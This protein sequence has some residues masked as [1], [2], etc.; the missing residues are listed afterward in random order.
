MIRLRVSDPLRMDAGVLA[1]GSK[2]PGV[3]LVRSE[4]L[5]NF[6]SSDVWVL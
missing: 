5:W 6:M 4:R 1:N 3:S 2:N